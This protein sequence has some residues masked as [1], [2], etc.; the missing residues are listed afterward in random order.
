MFRIYAI[1]QAVCRTVGAGHCISACSSSPSYEVK[2]LAV[3]KTVCRKGAVENELVSNC[4][5]FT[6][7]N[8]LYINALRVCLRARPARPL[9][10]PYGARVRG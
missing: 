3:G 7:S 1:S 4:C 5:K 10:A 9:P 8:H 6:A 2:R